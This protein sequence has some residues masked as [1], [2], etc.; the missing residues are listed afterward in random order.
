[1]Y[2][3]DDQKQ[4]TNIPYLGD[5]AID[6]DLTFIATLA[7][8][9]NQEQED[10]EDETFLQLVEELANSDLGKATEYYGKFFKSSQ[11]SNP[12]RSA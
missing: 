7:A 4:H 12:C 2:L 11:S 8:E 1:V 10:M 9:V 5:D 6:L 3:D